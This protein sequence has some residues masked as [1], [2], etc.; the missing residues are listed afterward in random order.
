VPPP[1]HRPA[2]AAAPQPAHVRPIVSRLA[3]HVSVHGVAAVAHPIPVAQVATQHSLPG[4]G[5]HDIG[6]MPR[7]VPSPSHTSLVLQASPS[8]HGVEAAATAHAPRPSQ[9]PLRPHV[10]VSASH[11]ASGSEPPG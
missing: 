1:L 11:S 10:V 5:A 2:A 4:P 3:S 6:A 7:H 8:S 9:L